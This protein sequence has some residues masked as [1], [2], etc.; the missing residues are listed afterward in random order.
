M[1]CDSNRLANMSNYTDADGTTYRVGTLEICVDG[2]YY[3]SCLDSLPNDTCN[4]L[5]YGN[6]GMPI[7]SDRV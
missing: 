3:P 5:F 4:K 2:I 6:S 1:E 7:L